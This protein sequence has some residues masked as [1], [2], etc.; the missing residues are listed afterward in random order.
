MTKLLSIKENS[1]YEWYWFNPLNPDR[2]R[3]KIGLVQNFKP[4]NWFIG[5]GEYIEDFEKEV[6]EKVLKHIREIKFGNNGYIFIINYD[7]IY[8]SHIRKNFIGKNAITNNDAIEIKKS[9]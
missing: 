9:Y 4:F 8:L 1:F 6:Q 7:S 5:T 2:Q 3:K